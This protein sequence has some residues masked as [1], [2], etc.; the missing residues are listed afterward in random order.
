MKLEPADKAWIAIGVGV[1]GF[2]VLCGEGGTLSE[3]CDRYMQHHPWLVRTVAFLLA[4]HVCNVV[5]PEW[6]PVHWAFKAKRLIR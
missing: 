1:L 5:K 6:D 3:A 2:D 4:A